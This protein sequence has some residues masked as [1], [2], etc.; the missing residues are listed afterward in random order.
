MIWRPSE[1]FLSDFWPGF[2]ATIVGVIL[3]VPAGLWLDRSIGDIKTRGYVGQLCRDL[4]SN[5]DVLQY[6]RE[7]APSKPEMRLPAH[8]KAFEAAAQKIESPILIFR[9]SDASESM[10]EVSQLYQRY[11]LS[12]EDA[13]SLERLK[14]IS[15]D[16]LA[17]TEAAIQAI[18]ATY[19]ENVCEK[20]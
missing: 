10:Q 17:K 3:S 19:G 20:D 18:K 16:A 12:P 8:G 15:E 5:A 11:R 2:A 6:Y 4:D 1:K 7:A 14:E 13:Q 9:I